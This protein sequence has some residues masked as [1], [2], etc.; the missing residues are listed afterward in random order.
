MW[1]K[2]LAGAMAAGI[3]TAGLATNASAATVEENAVAAVVENADS[4]AAKAISNCDIT[5]TLNSYVYDGTQ[6]T[7]S[8]V[9]KDGSKTLVCGTDYTIGGPPV[10]FG[11]MP[12]IIYGKGNYTGS[13][14]KYVTV[15]K[16]IDRCDVS[17]SLDSYVF[18]G[19]QK[20]LS[21]VV[22]DGNKT[23]QI[24][25]DYTI[26]SYP[27][28]S[29]S[30]PIVVTGTGNYTGSVTRTM[31][32]EPASIPS[33]DITVT[34]SD[35]IG[36]IDPVTNKVR[37]A[38]SVSVNFNG[39]VRHLTNGS[40]YTIEYSDYR[41]GMVSVKVTL[42][43][44][45]AGFVYTDKFYPTE[46]AFVWGRDNFSF[47][48]GNNVT[49]QVYTV[50]EPVF[51]A[52]AEKFHLTETE[53]TA[54]RNQIAA[55]NKGGMKG[56]CN[57]MATG[58]IL[59]K[60]G[61][62]KFSEFIEN[63]AALSNYAYENGEERTMV[64]IINFL[65]EMWSSV[66]YRKVEV[67]ARSLVTQNPDKIKQMQGTYIKRIVDELESNHSLLKLSY[68]TS[69]KNSHALTAYGVE[70][71]EYHSDTTGRDYNYRVLLYDPNRLPGT[72]SLY[73]E[74]CI[75]VNK[76][77]SGAGNDY[78]YEMSNTGYY[79]NS[80]GTNCGGI[81]GAYK[82]YSLTDEYNILNTRYSKCFGE[83]DDGVVTYTYR[84]VVPNSS[85]RIIFGDANLDGSVDINDCTYIQRYLVEM[86]DCNDVQLINADVN[87]DGFI[88]IKD[89]THLSRKL[90]GLCD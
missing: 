8:V 38:V 62:L 11:N 23:L 58:C 45:Y 63:D 61:R 21:V 49:G 19:Q 82:L 60:A 66:N 41:S 14:T 18:D 9:V 74:T 34:P 87:L 70:P 17:V 84:V 79:W 56:R 20:H 22:K 6:K 52:L 53:K 88:N 54:L 43:G 85:M 77:A 4:V 7:V 75:Y 10:I 15:T 50:D 71:F 36:Y 90:A 68:M 78:Y 44:A 13:V 33:S 30:N 1:K 42:K 37:N 28:Y 73:A 26:N 25:T 57:G 86:V 80:D 67:E 69:D 81:Y 72:N 40:G 46:P 24:G 16:P 3:L 89:V 12:V 59:S 65:Q 47:G 29:G 39:K 27:I 64:S 35:M 76:P 48:N 55:D 2:L 51:N 32:I 31:V 83:A 5:V